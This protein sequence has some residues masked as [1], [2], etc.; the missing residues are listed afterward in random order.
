MFSV[1]SPEK[2]RTTRHVYF[3]KSTVPS[4]VV[5][6]IRCHSKKYFHSIISQAIHARESAAEK[7]RGLLVNL[8]DLGQIPSLREEYDDKK[9][10]GLVAFRGVYNSNGKYHFFDKCV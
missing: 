10:V 7:L 9:K 8:E 4:R 5:R 2:P 3:Y 6:I 1:T